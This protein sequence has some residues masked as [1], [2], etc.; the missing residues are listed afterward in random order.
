VK[1]LRATISSLKKPRSSVTIGYL[2]TT[3]WLVKKLIQ[4]DHSGDLLKE[5]S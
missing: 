5:W 3:F 1:L 2:E 4:L